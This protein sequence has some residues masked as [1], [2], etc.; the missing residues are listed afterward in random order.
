MK[1]IFLNIVFVAASF[2]TFAQVGVGTTSPN[3]AAILDVTSTNKG[4]L[5]PRVALT[6]TNLATPL[7]AHVAG[8]TIY[9]TATAG[10]GETTVLPGTYYNDGTKWIKLAEG[11]VAFEPVLSVY[12]DNSNPN[13]ALTFD[14]QP[15]L[16]DD[17]NPNP[18][19]EDDPTL[20]TNSTYIYLGIDGSGWIWNGTAYVTYTAPSATEWFLNGTTADAGNNKTAVI[21]RTGNIAVG[22][23]NGGAVAAITAELKTE[24]SKG[25]AYGSINYVYNNS[26]DSKLRNLKALYGAAFHSNTGTS[27]TLFGSENVSDIQ[28]GSTGIVGTAIGTAGT[29]NHRGGASLTNSLRGGSFNVTLHPTASTMAP[30]MYT[31]LNT[32]TNNSTLTNTTPANAVYG[33][34]NGV[35]NNGPYKFANFVGYSSSTN[36]GTGGGV[37]TNLY[38]MHLGSSNNSTVSTTDV[39]NNYH[40][41]NQ[42][43]T[44]NAT[45]PITNLQSYSS[46][47]TNNGSGL[48]ANQR[49]IN[50]SVTNNSTNTGTMSNFTGLLISQ[51]AQTNNVISKMYGGIIQTNLNDPASGTANVVDL[52]TLRLNNNV[53]AAYTGSL[54]NNF[55]LYLDGVE[56]GSN[57]WSVYSNGGKSYF[58]DRVGVGITDP[59]GMFDV[60]NAP[61]ADY[62]Y[63][64]RINASGTFATATHKT[65]AVLTGGV[66][67][68]VFYGNGNVAL[69]LGGANVGI[70]TTNP[71]S[72]LQVVGLPVYANNA[73]AISAGL[74]AGAF[75]HNG[76]GIVRVVF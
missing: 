22:S 62:Q 46:S 69:A 58:K 64:T 38:L 48:V 39:L 12:V 1:K 18:D 19:Y 73:A 5:L 75:Y 9:N 51:A 21:K 28:N 60:V 3:T 20:E 2:T 63:S 14:D 37:P 4:L 57:N 40:G 52:Y 26:S 66:D 65:F 11:N 25:N 43:V 68:S 42:S 54:T 33:I 15:L 24:K 76:D 34:N 67:K 32:F 41:I 72:R 55:G 56:G 70:G 29:V 7:S 10:T 59:V 35:T 30:N 45:N 13:T 6:A 50:L 47:L 49:G 61:T 27:T 71:T 16:D 8:M 36:I 53:N 44:N 74:T 23:R 31:T 17:G